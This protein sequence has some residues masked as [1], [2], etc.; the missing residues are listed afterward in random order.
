M[1]YQ[2]LL[3]HEAVTLLPVL[4]RDPDVMTRRLP[5]K[6]TAGD[7]VARVMFTDCHGH[8]GS[9]ALPALAQDFARSRGR[10]HGLPALGIGSQCLDAGGP[11]SILRVRNCLRTAALPY[12]SS[13]IRAYEREDNFYQSISHKLFLF[14]S[15]FISYAFRQ[16]FLTPC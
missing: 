5:R 1:V 10:P 7:S 13:T 8:V 16:S 6:P 3:V 11:G 9:Q 4:W 2:A 12:S 14:L 15:P